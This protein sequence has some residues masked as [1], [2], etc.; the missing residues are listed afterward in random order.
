VAVVGWASGTAVGSAPYG[1]YAVRDPDPSALRTAEII[2]P[3]G[4]SFSF[5][6]VARP[7]CITQLQAWAVCDEILRHGDIAFAETYLAVAGPRPT[8][9]RSCRWRR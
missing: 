9:P 4:Q 2:V 5:P 8:L 6:G 7:G 3:G 1:A